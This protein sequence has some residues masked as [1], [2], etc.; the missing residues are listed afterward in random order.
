MGIIPKFWAT[1]IPFKLN[2]AFPVMELTQRVWRTLSISVY[3]FK[4]V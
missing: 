2:Y 3:L 1:I 4:L